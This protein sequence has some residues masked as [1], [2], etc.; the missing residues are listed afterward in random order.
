MFDVVAALPE[1]PHFTKRGDCRIAS[2][3]AGHILQVLARP[4]DA[5]RAAH[6][7]EFALRPA[8]P[9]SGYLVGETPLTPRDIAQLEAR[10]GPQARLVDQTHG[11]VR[12]ELSGPGA[13]RLLATGTAVDLSFQRFP[14]GAACETL[15]GHIGVH[16][17]RTGADCF[18]LL[19]GRSFAENLWQELTG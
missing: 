4:F 15:F 16:L 18:E 14:V 7:G 3:P 1:T 6:L 19:V 8:G 17:T 13:V 2:R 5:E 9:G 12:L 10:L 11:R